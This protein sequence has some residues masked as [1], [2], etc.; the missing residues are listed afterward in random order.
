[1]V[2]LL[3]PTVPRRDGD[4]QIR[5][6]ITRSSL[7]QWLLLLYWLKTLHP[8]VGDCLERRSARKRARAARP[9]PT[10]QQQ[11]RQEARRGAKKRPRHFFLKSNDRA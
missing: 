10:R 4:T 11:R 3:S 9:A 7:K 8:L 1:M 2:L 6:E 5:T